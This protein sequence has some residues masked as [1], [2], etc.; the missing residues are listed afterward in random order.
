ML[1]QTLQCLIFTLR[2]YKFSFYLSYLY[3]LRNSVV[4]QIFTNLIAVAAVWIGFFWG[5]DWWCRWWL[6]WAFISRV[7]ESSISSDGH[8]GR[9]E[10][11]NKQVRFHVGERTVTC[12]L[13]E[14]GCV[15]NFYITKAEN[16]MRGLFWIVCYSLPWELFWLTRAWRHL[17]PK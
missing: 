3:S 1:C 5:F 7:F 6:G 12:T 16:N 15:K 4:V 2:F 9:S 11:A 13:N 14:I 8:Y 10:K 17:A